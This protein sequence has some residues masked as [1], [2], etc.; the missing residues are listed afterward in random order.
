M[1]KSLLDIALWAVL[2]IAIGAVLYYAFMAPQSA[3][4]TNPLQNATNHTIIPPANQTA[5]Q[6][7]PPPVVPLPAVAMTTISAPGCPLCNS[8]GLDPAMLGQALPQFNATLGAVSVVASDSPEGIALISKYN[9][10]TLPSAVLTPSAPLNTSFDTVW[11]QGAGTI[12]T[13]GK[14]VYRN[15]APPYYIVENKTIAGLVDGVAINATGCTGCVDASIYFSSL[16]S[17]G[18][19]YFQNTTILQPEDPQAKQLISQH[20]ITKLPA[21]FLSENIDVYPFFTNNVAKLGQIENGWFVLRNVTPPY[22]D[23]IDNKSVKGLVKAVYV[24]N[25][26]CTD[27]LN[28]SQLSD[29]LTGSGGVYVANITVYDI[30]SADAKALVKKYNI[31]AI[32][33]V[34]YSPEASVYSGFDGAWASINSTVAPDGWFVFRS[35]SLLASAI[36]QNV[37]SGG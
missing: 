32:P 23:L 7:Q 15:I 28:I 6:T 11:L 16:Q 4:P 17:A 14:Y 22:E 19:I 26:S 35:H 1:D 29:Y 33:T 3:P 5:N 24:V 25:N 37:S 36:Y 21:L 8:S 27:C 18:K 12:E 9:I 10:T 31:S 30:S 2:G 34:L 20:N 13:D